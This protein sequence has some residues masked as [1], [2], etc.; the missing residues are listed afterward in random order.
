[1]ILIFT[2]MGPLDKRWEGMTDPQRIGYLMAGFVSDRLT[3]AERE[4]L[5]EWVTASDDHMQIFEAL[6][7]EEYLHSFLKWQTTRN[8]DAR[9]AETKLRYR[10]RRQKK[11]K[12][13]IYAVAAILI[14]AIATSWYLW[15]EKKEVVPLAQNSLDIPP[16]SSKAELRLPDGKRIVLEGITDTMIGAIHIRDGAIVYEQS[17]DTAWHEVTIPQ[18]GF[19][20]LQL[21]DGTRVWLNSVSSIRYPGR[22]EANGRTVIVTGEAY[23]QVAKDPSRPFV[24]QTGTQTLRATGTAFNIN[25]FEGWISL[26]EGTITINGKKLVP[27]DQINQEMVIREADLATVLAWTRNE[28]RF[29]NQTIEELKP[30]LERWYDIPIQI[31]EHI[32]FHFNGTIDRSVPLS[33]VLELLQETGQV[34]FSMENSAIHVRRQAP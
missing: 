20:R 11:R 5:D 28:F 31:D 33:R 2:H 30:I 3:L 8:I 6:T 10:Q 32:A 34:H 27:G 12:R 4:E 15:P 9:L 1:L 17:L 22:F 21:P 16:G 19:Y 24:V 18:K 23:F 14:A 29:R 26:E 13:W 25:G 7:E